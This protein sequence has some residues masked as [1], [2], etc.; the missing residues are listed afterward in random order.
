MQKIMLPYQGNDAIGE[1]RPEIMTYT[2]FLNAAA[3][4]G[5]LMFF[6]LNHAS[7]EPVSDGGGV[8]LESLTIE[9]GPIA[10]KHFQADDEDF[11]ERHGLAVIKLATKDY[12]NWGLYI[13]SPNSV[14][15][16][17]VGAGY[18]TDPYVVPLGPT[19]LEL[20]GALGLVTGYQDYPVPLL[21]GQARL[22]L[23]DRGNWNAGI[24]MAA[25]PYYMKDRSTSGDEWGIVAT[26]PFLSL[27]YSFD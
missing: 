23:F 17:S 2:Q 5:A 4:I 12:G 25:L 6:P 27:R 24:A 20:T 22:S 14:D 11:R 16:T 1:R 21:A 9:G 3:V 13:L 26:T 8:S 7:A 19:R 18:V 15:R 10:S